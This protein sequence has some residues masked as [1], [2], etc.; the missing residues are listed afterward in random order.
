MR[1]ATLNRGLTAAALVCLLTHSTAARAAEIVEVTLQFTVDDVAAVT[2]R[3]REVMA[4]HPQVEQVNFLEQN[5]SSATLR[6]PVDDVPAFLDAAAAVGHVTRREVNRNDVTAQL[7]Q[8]AER[9]REVRIELER[10]ERSK[11]NDADEAIR[12]ADSVRQRR[13]DTET[14]AEECRVTKEASERATIFVSV[15]PLVPP[16]PRPVD[17]HFFPGVR[18]T[19]LFD[20]SANGATGLLGL[21][22]SAR[23]GEYVTF[24]ADLYRALES[25]SSFLDG[26]IMSAGFDIGSAL[27][28]VRRFFSPH[29]G[30]R[31][32]IQRSPVES[33]S[34]PQR[35]PA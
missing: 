28:G 12:L 10:L 9:Q 21:G 1:T 6:L 26:F 34:P 8:C 35:R 13:V 5:A 11:P 17:P 16:A 24:E 32:G 14:L 29:L 18:G 23:F 2:T 20:A 7:R 19:H 15:N 25:R 3:L 22:L 31:A 27:F 30:V 4:A 33:I